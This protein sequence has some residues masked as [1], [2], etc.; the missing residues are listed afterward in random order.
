MLERSSPS[1]VCGLVCLSHTA[2]ISAVGLT[3]FLDLALT[4]GRFR[5]LRGAPLLSKLAI[6]LN[7]PS[8]SLGAMSQDHMQTF[9][10]ARDQL[11]AQRSSLAEALAGGYRKG[12]TENPIERILKVHAVIDAITSAINKDRMAAPRRDRSE[13]SADDRWR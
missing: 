1:P 8:A 3:T 13:P 5:R 12:Q 11:L 6:L 7:R 2:T 9:E 10:T 4:C